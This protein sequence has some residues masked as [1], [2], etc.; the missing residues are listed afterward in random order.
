M[1]M[2]L[3]FLLFL[4]AGQL[5]PAQKTGK[6]QLVWADEFEKDGKPDSSKWD[7]EE[8]LVRN[9]E[10]QW[11]QRENARC[12]NGLLVIEARRE[13]KP[14]PLYEQNSKD[15]RKSRSVIGYTSSCMITKDKYSWRYGRFEMKARIDISSGLW[16]AWWTLG[17]EKPWPEN[18]EID[19][20]EYYRDKLLANILCSGKNNTNEWHTASRS[21]EAMGGKKWSSEFHIWKM[22]W[23]KD[24]IA[25]YMDDLL[26][27]KVI[28]DSVV[29]KDGFGFNPFRQPHYMLLD[30]AIGGQNGGT[31]ANTSFPRRF[32]VD[33]IR[34]YQQ[35]E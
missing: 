26:L 7:Y 1:K 4:L 3:L 19:I 16:P 35:K 15:W 13:Q 31:P 32:E 12:E 11:Y 6:Y 17:I 8:G 18:G 23:T 27:N 5:L 2:L 14:N 25:I 34:I 33:Y 29:N 20:M 28:V 21:V 30:L 22:D 10:L 24:S 9:E